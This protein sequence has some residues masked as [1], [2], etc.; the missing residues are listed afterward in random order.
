MRFIQGSVT[1]V[2]WTEMRAKDAVKG[3]RF[4]VQLEDRR[5]A[6]RLEKGKASR[7]TPGFWPQQLRNG[8]VLTEM[9]K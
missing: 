7:M 4:C 1:A 9:E 8:G 2:V 3:V 5:C 6:G